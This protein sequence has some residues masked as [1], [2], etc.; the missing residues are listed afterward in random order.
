MESSNNSPAPGSA[1]KPVSVKIKQFLAKS[2]GPKGIKVWML[3][4][5]TIVIVAGLSTYV[6]YNHG[7]S[8]FKLINESQVKSVMGGGW[9]LNSSSINGTHNFTSTNFG[10]PSFLANGAVYGLEENFTRYGEWMVDVV[11]Q[12]NSTHYAERA[13]F[14]LLYSVGASTTGVLD[15]NNYFYFSAI[16]SDQSFMI[17]QKSTYMTYIVS[18]GVQFNQTQGKTLLSDQ[19]ALQ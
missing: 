3:V 15:G 10:G 17:G 9:S 18:S 13:Y 11:I 4:M 7:N 1:Q 2:M 12:Y 19:F 14:A 16:F 8:G 6:V 5:I